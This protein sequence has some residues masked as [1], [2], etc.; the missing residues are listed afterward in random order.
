MRTIAFLSDFGTQDGY[1]AIIQGVI[2]KISP[3]TEFITISNEIQPFNITAALLTLRRCLAFFPKRSIFLTV[4]DPGVGTARRGI[5]AAIGPYFFVGPDNGL[6]TPFIEA[7]QQA[8]W[9][10]RIVHLDQPHYWL[11]VLSSTFH[12]RDVFAPVAAYLANGTPLHRLGTRIEDVVMQKLPIPDIRPG[13]I[14]GRV[15]IID[16]FG[17]LISNIHTDLIYKR[18][19]SRI[20][21]KDLRLNQNLNA[22]GDADEGQPL[23]YIDSDGSFAIGIA[24]SSAAIKFHAQPGDKI[25]IIFQ[26]EE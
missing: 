10:I 8:G 6:I 19:I 23:A 4:I 24:N 9:K 1:P 25:E 2:K 17:N 21:Y 18:K 26:D 20:D 7:S 16:H 13:K 11:R 15:L 14:V 12:G 5:A 3:R 22:F